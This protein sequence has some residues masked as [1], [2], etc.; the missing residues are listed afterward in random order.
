[1]IERILVAIDGSQPADKALDFAIDMA[2]RYSADLQILSVVPKPESLMPRFTPAAPPEDFYRF[3]VEQMEDR[4]KTVLS[5]ALE[6]AKKKSLSSRTSTRLLKGQPADK[7]VETA[8]EGG[9]DVII[10]G[11]RGLG[12][13]EEIVLGSVS[14]RV[15]DKATCTVLIV[16]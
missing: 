2:K 12:S 8:S 7:I 14:N 9:V 11:S 6:R 3:F 4:L 16:K 1:M 13:I 10:L 15:A 5:D